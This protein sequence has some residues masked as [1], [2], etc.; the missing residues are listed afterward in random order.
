[1]SHLLEV[2]TENCHQC[3]E[4]YMAGQVRNINDDLEDVGRGEPLPAIA[5]TALAFGQAAAAALLWGS[6]VS[7]SSLQSSTYQ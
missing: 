1:M 7:V 3:L 4:L 5:Y 6:P 2:R